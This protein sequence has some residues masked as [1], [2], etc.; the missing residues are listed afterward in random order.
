MIMTW[1]GR[2]EPSYPCVATTPDHP[3]HRRNQVGMDG[4]C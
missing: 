1:P 4:F 3:K 2:C